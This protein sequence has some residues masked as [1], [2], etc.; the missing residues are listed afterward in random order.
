MR[1]PKTGWP[2]NE[3]ATG[4]GRFRDPFLDEKKWIF[5][6]KVAKS[7]LWLLPLVK[8][9]KI[10]LFRTDVGGVTDPNWPRMNQYLFNRPVLRA[11][12]AHGV[13][14]Y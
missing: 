1:D 11:P 7:G 6:K 14:S 13:S 5:W 4:T 9:A 2:L 8:G 10:T 12:A 3:L